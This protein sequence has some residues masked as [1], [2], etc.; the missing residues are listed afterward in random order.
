MNNNWPSTTFPI[1]E[2]ERLI[3]RELEL[4]DAE[5]IF[6]FLSDEDIVR[7]YDPPI[8][9]LQQARTIIQR[10]H[11]RFENGDAIR[12]GITFRGHKKVIGICGFFRDIPNFGAGISYILDRPYWNKGI[13]TEALQSM[14]RFGFQSYQLN[15]IEAH[16]ALPNAASQHVL[17]KLGFREEGILRQ[18]LFENNH[19]HD[20]KV[21][22]LIKN[23]GTWR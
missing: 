19:F 3:L 12:W 8:L 6:Q 15:R 13:V 2:T 14:L 20:E 22:A 4:G 21:F 16:V 9:N 10:H 7:Y 11:T 23:D 17:A 1:L 18:R 5:S